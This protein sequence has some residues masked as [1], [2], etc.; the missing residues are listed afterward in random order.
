MGRQILPLEDPPQRTFRLLLEYDGSDFVGWQ[1]QAS[2]RTVQGELARALE[3][4]FK[5][6]LCPIG[7]GRT[8]A[9][10]HA[11]GQVAHFTV[12]SDQ[13][14]DRIL[15]A[16]NG[17]LPQDIAVLDLVEISADF[18]ARY[19]ATGKRYRYRIHIGKSALYRSQVWTLHHCLD[20]EAMQK[21]AKV[22]PGTHSFAAFC[23]QDPVPA[24]FMCNI[25][26]CN[27]QQLDRQLIFEIEANRFLR[28]MVRILVGTMVEIGRGQRPVEDMAILLDSDERARAGITAPAQGLCLLYVR[29]EEEDQSSL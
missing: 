5:E 7:S 24:S 27:W 13:P 12:R 25:I 21:A 17:L 9:G 23:K 26:S 1:I 16:I 19:S 18:H 3:I 8:D 6:P 10:T 28:H 15:R 14:N 11:R 20:L 4:F 22:L 29:Y 2:G